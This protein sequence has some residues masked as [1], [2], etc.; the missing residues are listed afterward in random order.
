MGSKAG[1]GLKAGAAEAEID[2]FELIA[3]EAARKKA[4]VDLSI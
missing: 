4:G 3:E 1:K 2:V